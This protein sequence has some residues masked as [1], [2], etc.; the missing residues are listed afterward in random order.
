MASQI[1]EEQ[2]LYRIALRNIP[3][4]GNISVKNLISHFGTAKDV[5]AASMRDL[6]TVPQVGPKIARCIAK[7]ADYKRAEQELRFIER[8]GLQAVFY[9]DENYPQ[10]LRHY[11]DSPAMLFYKGTA[12]WNAPRI[13]AIV[14]TRRPSERGKLT[15][16]Q[17]V[18]EL[19]P[20]EPLILSGLAYGVDAAAHKTALEMGLDTIGVLAHGLD[21]VYPTAHLGLARKMTQQGGLLTEYPSETEPE[22]E[23]FPSRNRIIAGLCDAL[24]VI[25]TGVTG[26]SMISANLANDYQKDVFAVPGRPTDSHSAGCNLLIK[27]HRAALLESIEDLTY[28]L[29]WDE[30]QPAIQTSLFESLSGP[31]QQLLDLLSRSEQR[32][33]DELFFKMKLGN[34]QLATL[35]LQLEFKGLIKPL[36]GRFYLRVR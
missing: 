5:L 18:E 17:L 6:Q 27:S 16:A 8:E 11:P 29:R 23:H 19:Q 10:R 14:G 36:P 20:Y 24:I 2:W 26:G 35:L 21:R 3:H 28:V 25:E 7:E 13:V 4:I 32:H 9:L 22:R 31:E 12:D 34:G 30:E 33:F 1:I 15:T